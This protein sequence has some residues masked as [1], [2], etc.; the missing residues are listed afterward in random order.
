MRIIIAGGSG[1]LGRALIHDLQGAGH[2]VTVLTR[3]PGRARLPTGCQALA[4]DGRTT[5]GWGEAMSRAEAVINLTGESLS[6]WPWTKAQKERF[7]ES[8]VQAG[9]A[10]TEA[11]GAASPR[12]KVFIQFSGINHYGLQGEP[13]DENTPPGDDFLSQLTVVWEGASQEVEALGVR[14]CVLRTAVVLGRDGGLLGLMALPVRLFIGGRLGNGRQA[15]PWV[16]VQDVAGAVRFLLENEATRGVYNLIAPQS[17]SNSEFYR[18]LA[19]ALKRPY[20]FPTPAFLLRLALGEMAVLI[21]DGRPARP[22]RLL[23]AGYAFRFPRL[24]EALRGLF[25]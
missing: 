21:V 13:A 17:T 14:R 5:A 3:Y 24:E 22:D 15:V 4:W 11:I 6:N 2:E 25:S 18:G 23:K 16:H 8:R 10:L 1:F 20:W 19:K 12:P 7:R 9:Q